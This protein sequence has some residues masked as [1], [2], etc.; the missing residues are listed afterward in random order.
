MLRRKK[1]TVHF[2]RHAESEHNVPPYDFKLRDPYLTPFGRTQAE[3]L[4]QQ[5]P[6]LEDV[7]LVV[8]SPMKR[9]ISTALLAFK[10]Y[11]HTNKL[12]LIALPELQ[13]LSNK[14]CDTGSSLAELLTEFREEPVD[15]N[16]V[17]HDWDSKDRSADT[18][19]HARI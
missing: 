1:K 12:E 5:I 6:F 17:P 10:H 8:C 14:P 7:D 4:G 19:T 11:L 2:I 3:A 9:T 13:E 18:A 16:W 15:L